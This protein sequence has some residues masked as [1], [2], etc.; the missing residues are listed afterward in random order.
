MSEFYRFLRP[1]EFDFKRSQLKC[2]PHGGI[3]FFVRTEGWAFNMKVSYSICPMDEL[4]N[5]EVARRTAKRGIQHDIMPE[6]VTTLEI[7]KATLALP[8]HDALREN[9]AL[10]TQKATQAAHY[11][12]VHKEAVAALQLEKRYNELQS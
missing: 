6:A 8:G 7:I 10:I 5:R 1:H 4:F 11:F 9:V 3:C 12:A 2:L